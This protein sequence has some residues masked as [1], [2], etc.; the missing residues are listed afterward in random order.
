MTNVSEHSI[1]S[2]HLCKKYVTAVRFKIH[3][4]LLI[5]YQTF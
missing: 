1:I 3:F 5:N 4:L 2:M